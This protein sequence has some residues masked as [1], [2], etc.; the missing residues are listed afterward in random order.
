MSKWNELTDI[1]DKIT[2][3]H[4]AIKESIKKIAI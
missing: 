1:V 2:G 4:S 3:T